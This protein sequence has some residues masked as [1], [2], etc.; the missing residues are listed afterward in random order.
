MSSEAFTLPPSPV[1][2]IGQARAVIADLRHK[3]WAAEPADSLLETVTEVERLKS[4]LEAIEL[5]AIA[6]AEATKAAPK[7]GYA[8]A[9]DFVTAVGGGHNGY[10][11]SSVRLAKAL[12]GDREA[13]H[14]AMA[15]GWLSRAKAQVIVRTID[16]L[17]IKPALRDRAEQ[18]ML[19]H[20]R[21]LNA[22]D[23]A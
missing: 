18:A 2:V 22:S 10:G 20:A 17:P 1:T 5:A 13:T 23:L 12:T 16:A 7:D 8:S 4:E 6:E 3:M 19:Q 9:A 11:S 21:T 15:A 14:Q